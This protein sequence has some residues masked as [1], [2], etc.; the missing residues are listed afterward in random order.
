[1]VPLPVFHADSGQCRELLFHGRHLAF[2]GA[3]C[4]ENHLRGRRNLIDAY[5]DG[6]R[7]GIQD[8][9]RDGHCCDLGNAFCAERAL[10]LR[11][12]DEDDLVIR[13]I[14]G[15]RQTQ[16]T[17]QCFD[18]IA[19][20][21][22]IALGECIAL[23]HRAR[24]VHLALD[25]M[26]IDGTAD[27]MRRDDLEQAHL[28]GFLVHLDNG[29]LRRIRMLPT[30]ASCSSSRIFSRRAFSSGVLFLLAIVITSVILLLFYTLLEVY[31]KFGMGGGC[32]RIRIL[33]RYGQDGLL[34]ERAA[35]KLVS[36]AMDSCG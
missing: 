11:V 28:A 2:S 21:C 32:G 34:A 13:R 4:L 14:L 33:G 7:H 17:V 5:A 22:R 25:D 26:R 3:D 16:L 24:A 20:P 36:T 10:R 31:T 30:F 1:M 6:T 12:L 8:S 9:R 29:G 15:A 19:V 18:R 23:S 27:V 35:Q